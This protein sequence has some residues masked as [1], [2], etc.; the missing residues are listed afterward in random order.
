MKKLTIIM[1]LILGL[2]IGTVQA[3]TSIWNLPTGIWNAAAGATYCVLKTPENIYNGA[4]EGGITGAITGLGDI[5]RAVPKAVEEV[6]YG[7]AWQETGRDVKDKGIINDAIE[8]NDIAH[9]VRNGLGTGL[10]GNW[11]ASG[12]NCSA[13]HALQVGWWT[14]T[15]VAA[16]TYINH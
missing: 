4:K 7:L 3:E 11:I 2:F 8:S 1:V 6:G 13:I 10:T 5:T 14:G 9:A 15:T 12:S 16:G